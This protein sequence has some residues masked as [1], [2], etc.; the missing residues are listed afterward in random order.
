MLLHHWC[1]IA[2]VDDAFG[3]DSVGVEH[4]KDLNQLGY[5]RGRLGERAGVIG[6]HDPISTLVP[7]HMVDIFT[8]IS[9]E[10]Q[11]KAARRVAC[12]EEVTNL[13]LHWDHRRILAELVAVG[14]RRLLK[15]D[16]LLATRT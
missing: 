1:A 11:V 16:R 2:T 5:G 6:T 7:L 3:R 9:Q 12:M 8:A 10:S 4:I 15:G 14:Q 13:R